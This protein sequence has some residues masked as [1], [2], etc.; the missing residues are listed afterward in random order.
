MIVSDKILWINT[1]FGVKKTETKLQVGYSLHFCRTIDFFS[2]CQIE[3]VRP[4]VGKSNKLGKN[5]SGETMKIQ[6]FQK[7]HAHRD[8]TRERHAIDSHLMVP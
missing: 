2:F 1:Q 3:F 5:R 6:R 7:V 4:N 8:A